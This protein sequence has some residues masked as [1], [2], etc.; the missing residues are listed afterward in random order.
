M[1]AFSRLGFYFS[2]APE[3]VGV[4][5]FQMITRPALWGDAEP[6]GTALWSDQS[7]DG[8]VV[9]QLI[10]NQQVTSSTLVPGSTSGV[11]PSMA[12]AKKESS[13]ACGHIFT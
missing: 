9:E 5:E 12:E 1:I 4:L 11:L 7:R 2:V 3:Q 6:P 13:G 8:S 10:R